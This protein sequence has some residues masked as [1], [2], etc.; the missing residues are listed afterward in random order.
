MVLSFKSLPSF[1]FHQPT[2]LTGA[3]ELLSEFQKDA[4]LLVGGTDLFLE[5]RHRLKKP[6]VV[7]DLKKIPE[8]HKFSYSSDQGLILGATT[9]YH[10]IQ[11][12]QEVKTHYT[13]FNQAINMLCDSIVRQRAGPI[14]NICTASPASDCA[15]SL[16]VFD[17]NVKIISPEGERIVKL[18][19]FFTGVKKTILKPNEIVTEIK[20]PP[21]N[22]GLRSS[23]QKIMRNSEDLA[24]VGVA[25]LFGEMIDNRYVLRV[26]LASVAPTPLYL[27]LDK[28]INDS[29][30][31]INN[32]INEIVSTTLAKISPISDVRGGADYRKHLVEFLI[33]KGIKELKEGK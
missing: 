28:I 29:N 17:A 32:R 30:Q 4:V 10:E 24:V 22:K 14:G 27:N 15:P 3:L 13:A 31:P 1:N 9:T 12:I 25:L 7:I 2:S 8:L 6:K 18:K 21:L 26:G 16:L 20:V 19:D 33:R 11:S 23:Y 5:L